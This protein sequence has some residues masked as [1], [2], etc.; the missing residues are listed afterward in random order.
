MTEEDTSVSMQEEREFNEISS[1]QNKLIALM[2]RHLV[3]CNS[4]LKATLKELHLED[5]IIHI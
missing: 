3:L 2:L 4:Y 5:L 1:G